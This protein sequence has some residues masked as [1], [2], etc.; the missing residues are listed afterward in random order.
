MRPIARPRLMD[1]IGERVRIVIN[2][3]EPRVERRL[4][5]ETLVFWSCWTLSKGEGR[6]QTVEGALRTGEWPMP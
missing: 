1:T 3:L 2:T 6:P 5:V 4:G